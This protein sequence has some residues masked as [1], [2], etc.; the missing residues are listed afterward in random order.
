MKLRSATLAT[1]LLAAS[2]RGASGY[3]SRDTG[4]VSL[5]L[6]TGQPAEITGVLEGSLDP[7]GFLS[8][9]SLSGV[10]C[11]ELVVE[12]DDSAEIA[13]AVGSDPNLFAGRLVLA[14]GSTGQPIALSA[15]QKGLSWTPDVVI[16]TEGD[17]FRLEAGVTIRNE[18]GQ[19]WGFD[20][21]EIV[22]SYDSVLISATQPGSIQPGIVTY[23]WRTLTGR[24]LDPVVSYGFPVQTE[25]S[26]LVPVL[27]SHGLGGFDASSGGVAGWTGDTLW[28][29]GGDL[30]DLSVTRNPL[31]SGYGFVLTI[32]NPGS[33][34]VGFRLRCPAR[35]ES[36][37]A[38]VFDPP[39]E[40]AFELPGGGAAQVRYRISYTR[41]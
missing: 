28:L 5:R 16:S 27:S 8:E 2:C 6:H 15:E 18:T 37:A 19:T 10:S 38:V 31:P 23:P 39:H 9:A 32:E 11:L 34:Q 33:E 13:D 40:E 17:G 25:W 4:A 41:S 3:L 21:L 22:D 12:R 1:L 7:A 29:E 24:I 20:R 14:V 26:V 30:L 36:G 35:L